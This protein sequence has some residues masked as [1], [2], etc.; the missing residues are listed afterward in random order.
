MKQKLNRLVIW[1]VALA[2]VVC[3][4]QSQ[5]IKVTLLGTGTP[6]PMIER[7]SM[8]TLVQAGGE[9]LL[10]DAGR[11]CTIRLAQAGAPLK[12]VSKLFLTHLHSDHTVGIPDLW[13]TGWIFNR[14]GPL[15]VWGPKG[16]SAMV[17]GLRKAYAYDVH[18][19]RDVDE[20]L[21]A[22]GAGIESH[23]ISFPP[24]A[25]GGRKGGASQDSGDAAVFEHNGVKVTAFLV[26]HGPVKP[27]FGYRV[28]YAGHSVVLSGDTRPTENLVKHAQGADVLVHEVYALTPE[29]LKNPL[30]QKILAHHTSPEQAGEI[31]LRVKPKLAVYSHIGRANVAADELMRRTRT[32]YQGPLEVGEDLMTIEVGKEVKVIPF[33]H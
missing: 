23:E 11:G 22:A 27:A 1:S 16:A 30:E 20:G 24:F 6:R 15:E 32:T 9:T 17:D 26:D 29:Q 12:D 19:R 31:F 5:E 21:S 7:F 10:F 2:V 14:P 25:N 33:A 8:S 4:A 13:L 28:D 3:T 18:V